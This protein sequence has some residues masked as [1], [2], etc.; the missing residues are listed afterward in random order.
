MSLQDSSTC[1]RDADG[2]ILISTAQY[3][4]SL[5]V[6]ARDPQP[7]G[8]TSSLAAHPTLYQSQPPEANSPAYLVISAP[9]LP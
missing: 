2:S 6:L 3:E 7:I 4:S 9:P 1:S 5:R 8:F